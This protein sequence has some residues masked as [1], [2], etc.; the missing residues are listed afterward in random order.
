MKPWVAHKDIIVPI[1]DPFGPSITE[2]DMGCIVVSQETRKGG[3]AVNKRR[4]EKVHS[5]DILR[6]IVLLQSFVLDK[7]ENK[8]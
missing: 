4:L 2:A 8:K 6:L 3:A 1:T 7:R 5:T